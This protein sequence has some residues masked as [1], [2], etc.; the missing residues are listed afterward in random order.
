MSADAPA[1][2]TLRALTPAEVLA[3]LAAAPVDLANVINRELWDGLVV[4]RRNSALT[5][6]LATPRPVDPELARILAVAT[7]D[8]DGEVRA[9]AL[10]AMGRQGTPL[11]MALDALWR[12]L[13][14]PEPP[15]TAA[16][17]EGL[18]ALVGR[19]REEMIPR[20]I[21][22]LFAPEQEI[23]VAAAELL[24]AQ[25]AAAHALLEGMLYADRR[26]KAL[27][28]GLLL[29][30]GDEAARVTVR[31][32]RETHLRAL[33]AR[34]LLRFPTLDTTVR[35][36]LAEMA[37]APEADLAEAALDV[38][39]RLGMAEMGRQLAQ[40]NLVPEIPVDGWGER[41]LGDAELDA[42]AAGAV[43]TND[44]VRG[45]RDGR[46]PA[47]K[48][49][50]SVVGRRARANP[51]AADGLAF[52]LGALVRDPSGEVRRTA[53]GALAGIGG[54][55]TVE[56]LLHAVSD[57]DRAVAEVARAALAK[58]G[59]ASVPWLLAALPPVGAAVTVD[60][61]RAL[62]P[63]AV[64]ALAT[65]V[66]DE[67][68]PAAREAAVRALEALGP[69]ATAAV[70]S[71]IKALRDPSDDVAALAARALGDL[72][73]PDEAALSALAEA[74]RQGSTTLRRAAVAATGRLKP[75]VSEPPPPPVPLL[76]ELSEGEVKELL[77]KKQL[78]FTLAATQVLWDGH[79]AMRRN[80]ALVALIAQP[81]PVSADLGRLLTVATKDVDPTV[82]QRCLVA[83]GRLGVDL[84]EALAAI[85]RGLGDRVDFVRQA[86][87]E[88]LVA[89][90]RRGGN[91]VIPLLVQALYDPR[92]EIRQAVASLLATLPQS[93]PPLV[94]AL[95]NADRRL[96]AVIVHIL[97]EQGPEAP[98]ALVA[99][100]RDPVL[101]PA[102]ARLLVRIPP[103]D[104]ATVAELEGLRAAPD[105]HVAASAKDLCDR[106]AL[107]QASAGDRGPAPVI[108]VA[109]W[110]ERVLSAAELDAAAAGP[111]ETAGF[112]R[113]LRDGSPVVRANAAGVI[114]RRA[115]ADR[116]LAASLVFGLAVLVRDP[117]E[118]VRAAAVQ[119]LA[120][121]G[122]PVAVEP[123][124]AGCTDPAPAIARAAR[125]GLARLGAG[126]ASAILGALRGARPDVLAAAVAALHGG[127]KAVVPELTRA[128]RED[129]LPAAREVAVTTLEL[130]GPEAA[131][132]LPALV[133]ALRDPS[134]AVCAA[135]ARTLGAL[136]RPDEPVLVALAETR[137]EGAGAARRA[138][139]EAI[140]R[141]TGQP[142]PAPVP[143]Y[144]ELTSEQAQ[145]LLAKR[146]LDFT[147]A[148]SRLL[149]DGDVVTRRNGALVAHLTDAKLA[150][151]TEL[152]R[153][154]AVAT[155]DVDPVVRERCLTAV[156]RLDTPFDEALPALRRGLADSVEAVRGA[157]RTGLLALVERRKASAARK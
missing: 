16:A 41:A 104:R 106:L 150:V 101:R 8:L 36:E 57:S 141:L 35:A 128:L 129:P 152:A 20:L 108:P 14:D 10:V 111:V 94:A 130:L 144:G 38:A 99:A 63:A 60:A 50:A 98:R 157:A 66:T 45:L 5:A 127:G 119:A 142:E 78:D 140:A 25:A 3:Q 7:K 4:V 84:D 34:T 146:E 145:G 97:L 139:G 153:L 28:E 73:G 133:A 124:L 19:A 77:G 135:A 87:H 33:A 46:S 132:A 112:A 110:S 109:G 123:L 154:L 68:T 58:L 49:A 37:R 44:L 114:G 102:A 147:F 85:L 80:A 23:Q 100:L 116:T 13:R 39:T 67:P 79:V 22:A 156:G 43:A 148:V 74:R 120:D 53:V 11:E 121:L 17:R 138:A 71:L 9:H 76:G 6:R 89:A 75:E 151:P 30:Q 136:A 118:D 88:G 65:A 15:V 26:V 131:D 64:G 32:L 1:D 27:L 107:D 54:E 83:V 90:V 21:K 143:L 47:R 29:R 2:P 95:Q 149:S 51:A 92:G 105:P 12:G 59:P 31:A 122:D 62:G 134:D 125:A 70:P 155:R 69:P 96:Q 42:A 61:L 81:D 40:Q 115:R 93:A 126:A 72:A 55:A 56:P 48:N 113:A 91:A 86:A 18:E 117:A 137:R 24:A 103:G 52:G 82:R